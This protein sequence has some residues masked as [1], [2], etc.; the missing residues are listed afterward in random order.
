MAALILTPLFMH[1]SEVRTVVILCFVG[2][3]C[4]VYS[5]PLKPKKKRVGKDNRR[6]EAKRK[7]WGQARD[8]FYLWGEEKEYMS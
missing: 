5:N 7:F 2:N 1:Y 6:E 8:A 4:G 3:P